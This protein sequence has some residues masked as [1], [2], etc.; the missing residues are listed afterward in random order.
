MKRL[1]DTKILIERSVNNEKQQIL[2]LGTAHISKKS[3]EEVNSTIDEF[4]PDCIAL[5]LCKNRYDKIVSKHEWLNKDIFQII[6]NKEHLMFLLNIILSSYQKSMGEELGVMPGSEFLEA[7]KIAKEKNIDVELVDRDINITLKRAFE[8][9][10]LFDKI[11][12]ILAILGSFLFSQKPKEDVIEALKKEDMLNK[13]LDEFGKFSKPLKEVLV[14]E[15]NTYLANKTLEIK[16]AKKILLIVGAGHVKEIAKILDTQNTAID[17]KSLE[18]VKQKKKSKNIIGWTILIAFICLMIYALLSK[19]IVVAA[20]MLIWWVIATGGL[21]ALG[22]LLAGASFLSVLTAF[23][24]APITTI[25]P[26]LA[27]GWFAG[28][29]ELKKDKPTVK[30]FFY[31][32]Q[33]SG[34]KDFRKNR[35]LKILLIVSLTNLGA[36]L[37]TLVAFP[38]LITYLI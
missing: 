13:A 1:T 14:D 32:K 23:L 10:G 18:Q 21:A 16:D 2:V 31:I 28:L 19:G 20:N 25:H 26:L 4:Q 12:I 29:V 3:V 35:V 38:L 17:L 30:D 7:N 5:E 34:L 27:A 6:N 33:I 36:S 15:R 8:K 24:V 22:A 11:K 9:T 37:G